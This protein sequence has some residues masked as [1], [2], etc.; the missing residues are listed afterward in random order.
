M[1]GH[2]AALS[3]IL[4]GVVALAINLD[5]VE[6]DLVQLARTWWPVALIAL[7]IGL[8]LTPDDTR[9]SRSD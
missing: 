6:L 2:F 7:G 8:F 4:I 9:R 3:L 5:L 1:K